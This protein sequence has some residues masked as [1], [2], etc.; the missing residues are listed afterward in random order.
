[1][2]FKTLYILGAGFAGIVLLLFVVNAIKYYFYQKQI[3]KLKKIY[4]T[5]KNITLKE[6]KKVLDL[7]G[8]YYGENLL[9]IN[10]KNVSR[11]IASD[12]WY[13][14][15]TVYRKF[16]DEVYVVLKKRK[17]AAIMNDSKLYYIGRSGFIIGRINE[18][19]GYNF[20][21]ITGINSKIAPENEGKYLMDINKV[22]NFLK[23]SRQEN[24]SKDISELHLQNDGGIVVYTK[25]GKEIKFGNGNFKQKFNILKMLFYEIKKINFKY[26][27]YVNL[28]YKNEAVVGVTSG[29]RVL[30]ANYKKITIPKDIFR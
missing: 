19:I 9:N 5:G 27:N 26:K 7:S 25:S 1:M 6:R 10:L 8:L 4:I 18:K 11:L 15:I 29:S 13:K 23:L 14:D 17:V 21:I 12:R 22:L 20:P 30:P 28:E 2:R 16:P 24:F 3:F